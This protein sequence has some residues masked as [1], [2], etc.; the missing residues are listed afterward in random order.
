MGA[1]MARS[2]VRAGIPVRLWNR[3]GSRA[4]ALAARREVLDQP[5]DAVVVRASS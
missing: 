3:D 2:L 1:G 4:R 5:E